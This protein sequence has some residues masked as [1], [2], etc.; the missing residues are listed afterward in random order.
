MYYGKKKLRGILS[1]TRERRSE[2]NI[3]KLG[4]VNLNPLYSRLA[5]ASPAVQATIAPLAPSWR[6]ME[7]SKVMPSLHHPY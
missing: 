7:P 1:V 5:R 4:A 3:F 2:N 6:V